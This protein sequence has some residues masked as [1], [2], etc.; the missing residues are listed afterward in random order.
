MKSKHL[1]GAIAALSMLFLCVLT[2][3]S[4]ADA[5]QFEAQ[6]DIPARH[7]LTA[8]QVGNEW[9]ITL[10]QDTTQTSVHV[11]RGD[12][13]VWHAPADA[14]IFFQFMTR[15]LTGA[16][17]DSIMKGE[18]LTAVIGEEAETGV[19]P[20]AVFIFEERIYARGDSPPILIIRE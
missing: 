16:F 15:E 10:A 18:R 17:T 3:N 11:A 13:V 1:P 7:D 5:E 9:K 19:H 14:D 20:Y 12:T 8:V 4:C 2:V 6:A